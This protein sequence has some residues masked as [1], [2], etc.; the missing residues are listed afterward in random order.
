MSVHELK[1]W[2]EPFDAVWRG[3]KHHEVRVD[4]RG[5][6]VGDELLLQEWEPKEGLYSGRSIR[7]RVTH[8]S[9][10]PWVPEPLCV[11]SVENIPSR[12][13]IERVRRLVEAVDGIRH[14]V[15]DC[16]GHVEISVSPKEWYAVDAASVDVEEIQ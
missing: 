6:R 12:R 15:H 1:T 8:I 4:D 14:G 16:G 7:L 13:M 3:E 10:G 9:R 11:M 5:Y 2:P